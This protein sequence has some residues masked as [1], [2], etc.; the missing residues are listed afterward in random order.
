MNK[1]IL[2]VATLA[3]SAHVFANEDYSQTPENAAAAVSGSAAVVNFNTPEKQQIEYSGTQTLKNVPAVMAPSLTS[4]N[5]TCMGSTS[6]GVAVAGF[7]LSLGST[8]SDKNCL[9]LK[10]SRELWNMGMKAA[11]MARMCMDDLNKEALEL[12]GFVCP[13]KKAE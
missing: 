5:D 3:F 12:T 11:A 13:T 7:G 1:I 2:M 4:S 6:G 9:M 10:N 8:W